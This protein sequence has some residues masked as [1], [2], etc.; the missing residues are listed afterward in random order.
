MPSF[1]AL[2][3]RLSAAEVERLVRWIAA[4]PCYALRAASLDAAVSLVARTCR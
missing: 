3:Q 2:R 1:L 4:I